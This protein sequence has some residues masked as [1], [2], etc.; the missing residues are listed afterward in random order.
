MPIV[1]VSV[2][3][4][5]FFAER[6][7]TPVC[8]NVLILQYKQPPTLNGAAWHIAR[9]MQQ[10]LEY[11]EARCSGCQGSKG[12]ATVKG[13]PALDTEGLSPLQKHSHLAFEESR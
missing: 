7:S 13:P 1:T 3:S 4:S 10:L 11:I 8:L 12:K 2:Y 9:R 6:S 5:M